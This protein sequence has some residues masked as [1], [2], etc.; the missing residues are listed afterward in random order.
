MDTDIVGYIIPMPTAYGK[1]DVYVVGLGCMSEE[2]KTGKPITRKEALFCDE[3][4][5][6]CGATLVCCAESFY[7]NVGE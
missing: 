3:N 2:D 6:N 5:D 7:D 1:N 4:C